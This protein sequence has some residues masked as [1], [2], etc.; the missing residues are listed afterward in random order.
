MVTESKHWKEKYEKEYPK[1]ILSLLIALC[2]YYN[3]PSTRLLAE[4]PYHKHI[5]LYLIATS[6]RIGYEYVGKIM[7]IRGG[8]AYAYKRVERMIKQYPEFSLHIDKMLQL[9]E[10]YNDKKKAN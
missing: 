2:T 6:L 8:S 7:G 9:I 3:I 10:Q 1:V 5:I 4:S